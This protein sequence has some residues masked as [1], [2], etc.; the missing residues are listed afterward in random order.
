MVYV[1]QAL[2]WIDMPESRRQLSV[3]VFRV[4]MHTNLRHGLLDTRKSPCMVLRKLGFI[5]DINTNGNRNRPA[6]YC[7]SLTYRP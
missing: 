2:L 1:N 6:T 7:A 3:E 4:E 5:T